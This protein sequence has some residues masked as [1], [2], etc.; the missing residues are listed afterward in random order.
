MILVPQLGIKPVPPTLEAQILNHWTAGEL[1]SDRF[2][3][4]RLKNHCGW[5]L[6]PRNKKMLA[7]WKKG[8]D[9][10]RQRIK[11]QRHHFANKASYSQSYIFSSSHVQIW[12]L[13]HKEGWGLKNWCFRTV[14]PEKTFESPLDSKEIKPVSTKGNQPWIFIGRTVAE[15]EAPILWSPDVKSWFIG[16]DWCWERLKAKVEGGSRG[17]DCW[18]A[19]LTQWT[20][21]WANSRRLRRTG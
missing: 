16:K 13:D 14:V 1:Q 3:F 9:N 2:Y 20:C 7:S 6:Q 19:S 15:T 12:E 10:P 4:L 5:W 17:W 11:K 18:M 21:V 8:F